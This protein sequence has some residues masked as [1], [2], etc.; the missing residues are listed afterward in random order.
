M[1]MPHMVCQVDLWLYRCCLSSARVAFPQPTFR[2][3]VGALVAR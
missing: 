1:Y 2:G 3:P